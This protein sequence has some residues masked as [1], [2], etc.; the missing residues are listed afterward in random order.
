VKRSFAHMVPPVAELQALTTGAVYTTVLTS[1]VQILPD[2]NPRGQVDAQAF[3][4]DALAGLRASIEAD[5]ILTPLWVREGPGGTLH[6]I[7]GERRL[8]AAQAAA[9]PDV[10]VR[11]FGQ[12]DDRRA[13]QLALLENAQRT[14]PSLIEQTLAGFA[15]MRDLTGLDQSGLL[16]HLNA[17][18][19][20][21][22][23]D[24]HGLND[25]LRS[26]FGTGV[27][28]WSLQRAKI[29]NFTP[30]ELQAVQ[31]GQLDLKAAYELARAATPQ[32]RA[33]VLAEAVAGRWTAAQVRAALTPISPAPIQEAATTLQRQLRRAHQLTGNDA[34]RARVL[35]EEL[36]RLLEG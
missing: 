30:D 31:S 13:R 24:T 4:D 7:A 8:R 27:S 15:L 12:I 5:G 1:R 23:E 17:L 19:K 25:W 6:L 29:L 21:R 9:L 11:H 28:V 3:S 14:N 32:V 34:E 33:Q 20:G 10:P 35:M 22:E 2:F 26:T 16:R 18:R 36:S